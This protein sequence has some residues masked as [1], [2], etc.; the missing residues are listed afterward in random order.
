MKLDDFG[1][2]KGEKLQTL[3]RQIT[4]LPSTSFYSLLFRESMDSIEEV[5]IILDRN[6]RP[7]WANRYALA[8]FG[9]SSGEFAAKT[10]SSLLETGER[11][12]VSGIARGVSGR[13]GGDAVFLTRTN[14]RIYLR[15][16]L[17]PLGLEGEK[18]QGHLFVGRK[19]DDE[20]H[21]PGF[22]DASNG[23]T[24]RMLTSFP[25]P[26]FIVDG[27]TRLLR[28]CNGATS[29]AFGYPRE[30]MIGRGFLDFVAND[31]E[32]KQKEA[33]LA[34]ADKAYATAGV[35]QERILI[36]RKALPSLLCDC[37][38]LPI[39]KSDGSL[40]T[41]IIMLFDRSLEED[42][43]AE[44]MSVIGRVGAFADELAEVAKRHS[45][46]GS[47][48]SISDLGFTPRQIEI[49]RLVVRG[50]SSKDIAFQLGIVESTVKYHLSAIFQKLGVA[51]RIEFVHKLSEQRL[52]IG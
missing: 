34:R 31:A 47:V 26:L 27:P 48:R 32:R 29:A 13:Q 25:D 22:A 4:Q 33:L 46:P 1:R 50:D 9:Y 19:S 30:E 23:L 42:C 49:S 37:I 7:L 3:A 21:R 40:D 51:S 12:R 10:L 8:L 44:L 20:G 17:I 16:S 14:G 39:F 28:D 43:E 24:E 18:P 15:F 52:R 6:L 11:R 41:I 2:G 5:V 45:K 35:F 36:P 38:G